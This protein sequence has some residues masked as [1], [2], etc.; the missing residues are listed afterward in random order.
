MT[1]AEL[2]AKWSERREEWRALGVHLD[3]EKVAAEILTDLRALTTEDTV[4]LAE[5]AAIGGYSVDH[6]QRLVRRRTIANAGRKHAPRLRRSDVPI[7]PGNVTPGLPHLGAAD[8]LSERRRIVADA[9]AG[10]GA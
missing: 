3:G 2:V 5:A 1:G 6:L 7:K 9:I 10:E 8:Q 4:T